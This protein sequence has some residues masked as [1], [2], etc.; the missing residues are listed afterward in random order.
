MRR[1]SSKVS[2]L[3]MLACSRISLID[4]G[5]GLAECIQHLEAARYLLDVGHE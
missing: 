1:A 5:Q 4:V 3:V 2:T